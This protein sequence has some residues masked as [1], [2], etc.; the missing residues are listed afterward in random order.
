MPELPVALHPDYHFKSLSPIVGYTIPEDEGV[1]LPGEPGILSKLLMLDLKGNSFVV[2][3]KCEPGSVITRHY[4]TGPVVGYVL[5]GTWKYKEY[6]WIARA[7]SFVYEAA[8]E[9]HTLLTFGNEPM[10]TVFHNIGPNIILD[11]D[12]KQIGY[13]DVFTVLEYAREYCAKNGLDAGYF[14]RIL[15]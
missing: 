13:N 7:G 11:D 15:R 1:W 14:D 6:D 9:A 4:H 12:G 10:L 2:L 5:Q 8:G 3:A